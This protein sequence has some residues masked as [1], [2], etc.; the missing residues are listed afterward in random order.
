MRRK[1]NVQRT[2]HGDKE[3]GCIKTVKVIARATGNLHHTLVELAELRRKFGN[4][5]FCVSP[6]HHRKICSG[7]GRSSQRLASRQK[8]ISLGKYQTQFIR[9]LF[10]KK[11]A[12][13]ILRRS[14]TFGSHS[15]RLGFEWL[16]FPS[17]T[18]HC[19]VCMIKRCLQQYTN[20]SVLPYLIVATTLFLVL[21]VVLS[22]F[23]FAL[24][25]CARNPDSRT[26]CC[27]RSDCLHPRCPVGLVQAI[28]AP[29][30]DQI[31]QQSKTRHHGEEGQ[32][33][34]PLHDSFHAEILSRY[35]ERTS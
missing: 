21:F 33:I 34:Q 22:P 10:L 31:H 12:D 9:H 29:K 7:Y 19:I 27:D 18:Y 25:F 28:S 35:Q 17:K 4:C 6:M 26:D 23:A 24:R 16:E 14:N 15:E 13:E 2:I 32:I 11:R 3:S 1:I 20:A 8:I 5:A 30:N